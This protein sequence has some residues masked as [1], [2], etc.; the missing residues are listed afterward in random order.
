MRYSIVA[1]CLLAL[2]QHTAAEPRPEFALAAPVP[3]TNRVG[4]AATEAKTI[5][6]EVK[7]YPTSYA[8]RSE[9]TLLPS[10]L[11][12]VT[13]VA[14]E[15]QTL[16]TAVVTSIT[17]LASDTSGNVNTMFG[18]A[19]DAVANTITFA[20]VTLPTLTSPLLQL[21]G[22][23]LV[24]KFKDSLTHISK[25]LQALKVALND[26]KAG[27]TN[28]VAEAGSNAI[29]STIVSENLPRSMV[30]QLVT[31]LQLLRATVPVL[32]YTIDST[33][34]GIKIGDQYMLDLS[35][36]VDST[37]GEK[38]SIAAD[39]D[40]I[41]GSINKAITDTMTAVSTDL[42]NLQTGY[43]TLTNLATAASA[44]KLSTA[45]GLFA[46]NLAELA[47][48]SP[49]ILATLNTLKDS[50]IDVYDVA[51]PLYF[52]YDSYL[53]NELITVLI[54]NGNYAQYCFYK[55]NDFLF[56]LLETVAIEA[57]E[58]VDKEVERL[59]FF[60]RT[61]ELML[62]LLFFDFEDISGDLTVCNGITDATN[63]EECVASLSDI[64]TRLE[65]SFGDMFAYGY[66]L[67]SREVKASSNRLKICMRMSQSSLGDTEIPLL[68]KNIA[69]CSELGPAAEND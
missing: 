16:G 20:D 62:N 44:G 41:I 58:C 67:V 49:T 35:A 68:M 17:N 64:Y 37:I 21:T 24:D 52:I 47:A 18:A 42:G 60:R 48:K 9:L 51:S 13:N 6:S 63:L 2:L 33:V 53:V 25:A 1:L 30:T 7:T 34:D 19:V 65:E 40:G 69:E 50:L 10:L 28:A 39:L 32:K 56:A 55:Y 36:K 4:V 3:G 11:T 45:L 54:G 29:T 15:F 5:I 57:R 12:I 8:I 23:A 43:A 22:N 66:D 26:L 27:A 14:T 38:S 46:G 61:V 59:E 31:A